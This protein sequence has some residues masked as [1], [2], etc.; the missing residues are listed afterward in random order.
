[1]LADLLGGYEA[2]RRVHFLAMAG[3]VGFTVVHLLP[4]SFWCPS[5]LRAMITGHARVHAEP[6]AFTP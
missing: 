2:A 4:W 6:E 1:M 5:T 3:I